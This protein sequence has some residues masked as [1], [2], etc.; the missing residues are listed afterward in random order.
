MIKIN[1]DEINK[2]LERT[3]NLRISFFGEDFLNIFN[4]YIYF[5]KG[6]NM[7]GSASNHLKLF[8]SYDK[9][10]NTIFEYRDIETAA[11]KLRHP[12]STYGVYHFNNL[13]ISNPMRIEISISKKEVP[14][15]LQDHRYNKGK[16]KY[17]IDIEF[18]E[19]PLL[20][21]DSKN[22][23]IEDFVR[24]FVIDGNWSKDD[25]KSL[26][27]LKALEDLEKI[28][29][30]LLVFD[31]DEYIVE[32]LGI[33]TNQPLSIGEKGERGKNRFYRYSL[34]HKFQQTSAVKTT[35][36]NINFTKDDLIFPENCSDGKTYALYPDIGIIVKC[37]SG[38]KKVTIVNDFKELDCNKEINNKNDSTFI[39]NKLLS[40]FPEF[41]SYMQ[42][43]YDPLEKVNSFGYKKVVNLLENKELLGLGWQSKLNLA[44][45]LYIN[46]HDDV[47]RIKPTALLLYHFI[48]IN[49]FNKMIQC[50]IKYE[51][52]IPIK[53]LTSGAL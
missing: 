20:E 27:N 2:E 19:K 26:G 23:E 25:L 32:Y 24:A 1:L 31:N 12:G 40:L 7:V 6:L 51:P 17:V 4:D 38:W 45:D 44:S 41:D 10:I 8:N 50:E 39:K 49:E 22:L 3:K 52:Q 46:S 42:I 5:G 18:F 11:E 34:E 9:S 33:G 28:H 13:E 29:I 36:R 43:F 47:F 37:E 35:G 15:S 16:P 21:N 48:E 53:N 30:K 14:R